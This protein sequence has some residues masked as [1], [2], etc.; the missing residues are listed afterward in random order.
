MELGRE[1]IGNK[2]T[3]NQSPFSSFHEESVS[4]E[5]LRVSNWIVHRLYNDAVKETVELRLLLLFQRVADPTRVRTVADKN[6]SV[7]SLNLRPT[8][9]DKAF[10]RNSIE[11][12]GQF[13]CTMNICHRPDVPR[14]HERS[15]R[16]RTS[17]FSS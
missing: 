16:A 5:R 10:K 12:R 2:A 17:P 14:S 9:V 13:N 11:V 3:A 7:A 1:I 6:S 15:A 4:K 8:M